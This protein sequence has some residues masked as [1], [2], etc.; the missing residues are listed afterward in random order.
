MFQPKG[1]TYHRNFRVSEHMILVLTE[2]I[3]CIYKD[4]FSIFKGNVV[5]TQ[6]SRVVS[7]VKH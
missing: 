1:P 7:S 5:L 2:I 6:S 4:A 3:N